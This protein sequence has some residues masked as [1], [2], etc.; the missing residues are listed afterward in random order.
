[1]DTPCPSLWTRSKDKK[2]I[3]VVRL[4]KVVL[5]NQHK[6]CTPGFFNHDLLVESM[7]ITLAV[8]ID[9]AEQSIRTHRCARTFQQTNRLSNFVIGFQQ[10]DRID[11][12]LWQQRIVFFAEYD[13]N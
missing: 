7:I 11:A 4:H 12:L 10:Q 5:V 2:I 9:D 8:S 6:S 13:A 3:N 1:M